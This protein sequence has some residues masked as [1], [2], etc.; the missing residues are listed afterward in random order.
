MNIHPKCIK[1]YVYCIYYAQVEK[2]LITLTETDHS[3]IKFDGLILLWPEK[4][5]LMSKI[6]L[7]LT[8]SYFD[9]K[10]WRIS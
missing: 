4:D 9:V 1:I 2:A 10:K 5:K 3:L 8:I 7:C 6:F